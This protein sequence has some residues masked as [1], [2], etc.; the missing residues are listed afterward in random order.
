[1]PRLAVDRVTGIHERGDV[2]DGVVHPVTVAAGLDVQGLVQV[3]AA[4]GVDGDE[5]EIPTVDPVRGH[6][7]AGRLGPRRLDLGG[8]R[9]RDVESLPDGGEARPELLGVGGSHPRQ[10]HGERP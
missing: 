7:P 9:G 2:G 5:R 1:M 8:H 3:L 6:G 4:D 10:R